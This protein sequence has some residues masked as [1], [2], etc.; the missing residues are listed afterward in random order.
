MNDPIVALVFVSIFHIIGGVAV[1][2]T[3]RGL[4]NGFP[5]GKIFI[6]IWGALFGCMPLAIGVETF[7]KT[8][9]IYL[10]GIEILVLASAILGAALIP[11]WILE[12]FSSV[13]LF[14]LGFGGL[15]LLVG[16]IVGGFSLK[17]DPLFG[18]VFGCIFGGVGAV[19]FILG[20]RSLL[21]R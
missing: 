1:G 8:G 16:L 19:V 9:A 11:D 21:Q 6:L 4:R 18:L 3:L 20:L 2:S 12:S 14:P 17:T 13:D 7:T 5:C 10:L 15:F